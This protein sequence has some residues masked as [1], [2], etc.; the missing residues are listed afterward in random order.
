MSRIRES[1]LSDFDR[2]KTPFS[3]RIGRLGRFVF[4]LLLLIAGAVGT[5]VLIKLSYPKVSN[6]LLAWFAFAPFIIAAVRLKTF[7]MTFLYSWLTGLLINAGIFYW[8]YYTCLNG[9]GLS[10]ALSAA[11]W[12]GLSGIL[13]LQFAVFGGSCF[14]LK[15]LRLLFP[16][17]AACAWISLEWLHQFL[18]YHVAGFPWFM[19]GYT[20]WNAPEIIQLAAYTGVYGISFFLV[21]VGV[22]V[23]YAFSTSSLKQA[24]LQML[25]AGFCFVTLFLTGEYILREADSHKEGL[26]KVNAAIMQPNIDQYKKWSPQYEE[27]I[28]ASLKSLNDT[29]Q[30]QNRRL[31][32]WPESAVPGPLQE[33]KYADFFEQLTRESNAYQVVGTNTQEDGKQYV[34]AYMLSPKGEEWQP[35]F[36]MQLV[37]FGEYIPFEN[38]VRSVFKDVRILGELGSFTAGER[39]Q[40]LMDLSGL[41]FGVSICYESVFPRVWLHQNR[42]GA[43]FFVNITNDGWYFDT[44]APYQHL[45]INVLRAV[46][47]GRPVLRSANTG[48]SAVIDKTGR[49]VEK[50][51]LDVPAIILSDVSLMT[52]DDHNF[53]TDWGDWFAYLC[54]IIYFT[55]LISTMVFAYE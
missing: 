48:I 44:D 52:S 30:G 9:G 4:D 35:Y 37:P 12:L 5:A 1:L 14:F 33:K 19:L 27:E 16:L 31:I 22:S 29:V 32:I 42:Q 7:W 6:H 41:P 2:K 46:E 17:L 50:T 54:A 18:A 13:A 38:A 36:K 28:L 34:S 51:P 39:M 10:P 24:V 53:Y 49:L 40:P 3:Q 25:V 11:A 20:Q 55:F 47:T 26:L 23:G 8:I 21:F 15:R 45:A 43:K